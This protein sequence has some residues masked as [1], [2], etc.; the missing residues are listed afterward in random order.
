MNNN[1]NFNIKQLIYEKNKIMLIKGMK[2]IDS[3]NKSQ[4]S[5]SK[6]LNSGKEN[7][8]L[9]T[10]IK[11][12]NDKLNKNK[13]AR[14]ISKD[15]LNSINIFQKIRNNVDIKSKSNNKNNFQNTSLSDIQMNKNLSNNKIENKSNKQIM[16][17][18]KDNSTSYEF[19]KYKKKVI[20]KKLRKIL[21]II[22]FLIKI[23]IIELNGIMLLN[24]LFIKD[25]LL[26][27][28]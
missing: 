6:I 27:Y 16:Q 3:F 19:K 11:T 17:K 4:E 22:L 14:E 7:I 21:E 1:D 2:S 5:Y 20:N 10:N 24:I 23:K 13:G 25:Y 8:N 12:K 28:I 26:K 9:I 15:P 18:M